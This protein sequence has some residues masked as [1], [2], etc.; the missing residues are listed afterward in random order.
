MVFYEG[1][2]GGVECVA[3]GVYTIHVDGEVCMCPHRVIC[4]LDNA[5]HI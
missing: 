4:L 2:G 3:H 5:V 1:G